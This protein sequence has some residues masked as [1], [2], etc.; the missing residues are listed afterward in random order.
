MPPPLGGG[1]SLSNEVPVFITVQLPFVDMRGFSG[2]GAP[3]LKRP[4]WPLPLAGEF[5]RGVGHT[6]A[7]PLGG[8]GSWIGEP[9]VCDASRALRYPRHP[10]YTVDEDSDERIDHRWTTRR[11]IA[12]SPAQR[13]FHVPFRRLYYDGLAVG[14]V[15]LG[16]KTQTPLD[17][18]N[19]LGR[20]EV[21]GVVAQALSTQVAIPGTGSDEQ[22]LVE[23]SRAG[24]RFAEYYASS[25]RPHGTGAAETVRHVRSGEPVVFVQLNNDPRPPKRRFTPLSF[26][27][28]ADSPAHTEDLAL[29]RELVVDGGL[30]H[31]V[32]MLDSSIVNLVDSEWGDIS[33]DE[34]NYQRHKDRLRALRIAVL[35]LHAEKQAF[36]LVQRAILS[37]ELELTPRSPQSD[38]FQLY[39]SRAV[40]RIRGKESRVAD[41]LEGHDIIAWVRAF[42]DRL[43]LGEGTELLNNVELLELRLAELDV[44][45]QVRESVIR[46]EREVTVVMGDQNINLGQAG[47]IGR[48]SHGQVTNHTLQWQQVQAEHSWPEIQ[49]ALRGLIPALQRAV[50]TDEHRQALKHVQKASNAADE[51]DGPLLLHHLRRA[52]TWVGTVASSVGA[53]LVAKLITGSLQGP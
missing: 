39:L 48:N 17:R 34:R 47:S 9:T 16:F 29:A 12:R 4:L 37:C 43:T 28:T 53:E 8:I 10:F 24:P 1:G 6:H 35:R 26:P 23:L 32:W 15:E 25:S 5:V 20:D 51:N 2:S 18:F 22:V 33:L 30:Q 42:E 46:Y 44:R 45:P 27:P 21:L 13:L 14:K 52:G 11:L 3:V 49:Q 31:R 38:R 41:L 36:R 40:A 50:E 19:M 7:R